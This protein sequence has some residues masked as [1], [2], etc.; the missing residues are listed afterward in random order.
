MDRLTDLIIIIINDYGRPSTDAYRMDVT[1]FQFSTV[2]VTS[3][4][5]ALKHSALPHA[6]LTS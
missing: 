1:T 5:N 6:A 3:H 4:W 2:H